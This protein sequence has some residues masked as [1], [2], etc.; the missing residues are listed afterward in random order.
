VKQ[1]LLNIL[2]W[3]VLSAAFIGPGTVTTAASAGAGF[4]YTLVWALVFSTFACIILQEAAARLTVASGRNLGQALRARFMRTTAGR[5]MFYLVLTA[6]LLGCAA[7]EAGNILGAVA[8]TSLLFNLNAGFTALAIG[9][10]AALLLWFAPVRRVAQLLGGIVAVM[11]GCFLA[12]ALSMGP[13]FGSLLKG[14]LVP[15]IPTGSQLLVI[16]L[17][18][19]TVV[20]YNLFL[21]SGL[22]HAQSLTEMRWSLVSAI[23]LGGIVS[24]CVVVVGSAVTGEFTFEALAVKL[25][26]LLGSWAG[27]FFGIGLFAAG[28][29]SA[30][31][32]PLA[33]SVTA[34]SMLREG[35]AAGWSDDGYKF[36][37]VWASV[38]GS[39]ILF[40]VI[41][42]QPVPAIIL[43]QALN[44]IILPLIS[45]VLLL[46]VNDTALLGRKFINSNLH[47]LA[48]WVIIL[49]TMV[50]G[51]TNL[52]R[53]LARALGYPL[54]GEQFIL[55]L[56]LAASL[57]VSWPVIRI[58][59][60]Y[61]NP[62][63]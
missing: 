17:I 21:G 50:I 30:L 40:G 25:S 19:T 20:P 6:I 35:A 49:A 15:S 38:L 59:R 39:G 58:L 27:R 14:S 36:R 42:V 24:I 34:R 48:M 51:F 55:S 12:T 41:Q 54:V 11:G 53:A 37:A 47:N 3:S 33:A 45:I 9:I 16:G 26:D 29:S 10:T 4:G 56:S 22:K 23:V 18:G 46:T 1:R 52:A 8:G 7:Y 13:D 28:L 43:A 2:F 60:R 62:E 31:T 57:V 32:A 44:G 63:V 61:R 5:S